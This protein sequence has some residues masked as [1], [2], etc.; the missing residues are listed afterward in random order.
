[1]SAKMILECLNRHNP[2]NFRLDE[3]EEMPEFLTGFDT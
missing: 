2:I 1:M 3:I